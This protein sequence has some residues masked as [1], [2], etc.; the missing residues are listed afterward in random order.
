M[1]RQLAES[2][3]RTRKNSSRPQH[4]S[5]TTLAAKEKKFMETFT[6]EQPEAENQPKN[7]KEKLKAFFQDKKKVLLL[8]L[9]VLGLGFISFFSLIFS[10]TY[11]LE[12]K[13]PPVPSPAPQPDT[14]KLP[15]DLI[16]PESPDLNQPKDSSPAQPPPQLSFE[17]YDLETELPQLPTQLNLYTLKTN[18][19]DQEVKTFAAKFGLTNIQSTTNDFV[20]IKNLED[21]DNYGYLLF[22][23]KTGAFTFESFGNHRPQTS[24]SSD[25]I[26]IAE[27]FLNE[28]GLLDP[29]VSALATYQKKGLDNVTFVEFHRNWEQTGLPIL[30]IV[31]LLNLD[32]AAKL[33]DLK[34]GFIDP[35]A[36]DNQE[37]ILTSDN[38]DG[39]ARPNDF[40]TITVAVDQDGAI[41]SI[42]SNLRQLTQTKIITDPLL[43]PQEA[44]TRL[45]QNQGVFQMISP[46][47]E[48]ITDLGRVFPENLA[49]AGQATITDFV[50]A[51]LEKP[52][53]IS[54]NFLQPVYIFKG[55]ADLSSGYRATWIQAVPAHASTAQVLGET[56]KL[57]TFTPAPTQTPTPTIP[58]ATPTTPPPTPTPS[59]PH[60]PC[61]PSEADLDPIYDLA[62]IGRVGQCSGGS[63]RGGEWYFIPPQNQSLPDLTQVL[64]EFENLNVDYNRLRNTNRIQQEWDSACP[65][66]LTGGSPT[67]F[68]YAPEGTKLT[69]KSGATLTYSDPPLKASQGKKLSFERSLSSEVSFGSSDGETERFAWYI[70]VDKNHQLNVNSLLYP[71]LYYEY[72]PVTFDRPQTGWIIKKSNLENFARNTISP[73]LDLNQLEEDRL[74]FELNHAAF[75]IDSDITFIGPIAT[76][77]VISKL[78]LEISPQPKAVYRYHFYVSP[79]SSNIPVSQ[80]PDIPTLSPISR[81]DFM[82]LELGAIAP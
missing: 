36:P 81:S 79:V 16:P 26:V 77:D 8:T 59:K 7:F 1:I 76:P 3:S 37:I 17:K 52:P 54:Q 74:V 18:Y 47:G 75:S 38:Y 11:N 63:C 72:V 78:P 45:K 24:P 46:S 31:G 28:K 51:F 66:R 25:P 68:V 33:T 34:L 39:K 27:S 21:P 35:Q 80:Y 49:Q 15:D 62:G 60:K 64:A 57:G 73:Q 55:Y 70:I 29:T 65:K 53:A 14:S 6:K 82:I 43:S 58:P 12:P 10:R 41:L 61:V 22:N 67:L 9:G 4:F 44:L 42:E 50:L 69:I 32:Q 2:G 5:R 13:T 19:S 40:N 71:Y 23:K 48:G 20:L 30:N 56:I